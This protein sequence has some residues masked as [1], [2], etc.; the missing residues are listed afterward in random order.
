MKHCIEYIISLANLY[1]MRGVRLFL[2]YRVS[3][4]RWEEWCNREIL[5]TDVGFCVTITPCVISTSLWH[6]SPEHFPNRVRLLATAIILQQDYGAFHTSTASSFSIAF[7]IG[8]PHCQVCVIVLNNATQGY[9]SSR[10]V[11]RHWEV[12]PAQYSS[13]PSHS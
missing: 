1:L 2:V 7:L 3:P 11:G 5:G 10:W 6:S 9:F 13:S 8:L 4:C 12:E